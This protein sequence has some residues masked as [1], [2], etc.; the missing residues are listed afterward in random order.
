MVK[1]NANKPS[2]KDEKNLGEGATPVVPTEPTTPVI[3]PVVEDSGKKT[4]ET[5]L[6]TSEER[7]LGLVD[8]LT[9]VVEA[10]RAENSALRSQMAGLQSMVE[11]IAD[12]GRLQ[13]WETKQMASNLI[14]RKYN[15]MSFRGKIV[16]GWTQMKQNLVFKNA[17]GVW[18][19]KLTT[20]LI[21]EDNSREEVDYSSWQKE[22]V[23]KLLNCEKEEQ[24]ANGNVYLTLVDESGK[25]YRVDVKFVN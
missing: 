10:S 20:E 4:K 17:L 13:S 9:S 14:K 24:D 8:Q 3:P 22:R 2:D 19:E 15:L 1:A 6:P 18:Q 25:Q 7:L 21:Y 12:K 5:K 16:L 23:T 11:S